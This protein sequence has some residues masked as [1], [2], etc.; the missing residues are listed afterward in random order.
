LTRIE[1]RDTRFMSR[2]MARD[3]LT[4][5]EE[6]QDGKRCGPRRPSVPPG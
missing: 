2:F 4:I 1:V 3:Y 6:K 5:R